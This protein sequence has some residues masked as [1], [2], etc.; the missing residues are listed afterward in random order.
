MTYDVQIKDLRDSAKAARSAAG[1]IAKV[2]P[3]EAL[4]G[5]KAAMPGASSVAAMQRVGTDWTTELTDWA[6]AARAY[7][8][9][10]DTNATQYELD[11]DASRAA[12]GPIGKPQR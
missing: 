12:F 8:R 1:Q 2:T 3:G 5:A 7:G 6:K 10:L 11:D 9:T 4:T